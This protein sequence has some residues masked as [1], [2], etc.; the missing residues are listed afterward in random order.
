M[1]IKIYNLLYDILWKGRIQNIMVKTANTNYEKWEPDMVAQNWIYISA[2]KRL[3]KKDHEF[4]TN[5]SYTVS[6]KLFMERPFVGK[7]ERITKLN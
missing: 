3:K 1:S 6:L 7:I 5:L 4:K 2:S